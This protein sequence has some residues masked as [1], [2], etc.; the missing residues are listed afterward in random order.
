MEK[1]LI[2]KILND[3][4]FWEKD[5]ASGIK[6]EFYLKKMKDLL[7]GEQVIAITGP[8]RSGKSFLMRQLAKE[9]VK[10]GAEKSDI[11]MVNL[12]DP[13]F[14]LLDKE[15]L[16]RIYEVYLEFFRP[17]RTPYIFLDEVQEV[18]GWEKWVLM[19]QE[20]KKARV[21]IS[22]SNA[23][24]LSRELSTLL[25]GRH[26]DMIVYPLSFREFLEFNNIFIDKESDII[27]KD[28]DI[29]GALR[30]YFE[31]GA[32]PEIVLGANKK[33]GLLNYF[34][35]IL[36]KDLIKRY[37]IRKTEKFKDLL[38]FYFSNISSLITFSSLEK[39]MGFSADTI[40]KFSDYA[41]TAY[42][43]FFLKRF[44]FRVKEQEKSPRK[45]YAIDS[46]LANAVGFR[47]SENLGKLAE[48]I[49]FLELKR[50]NLE[51]PDL[52]IYY[53]KDEKHRE[54]DFVLYRARSVAQLIQ[55]CWDF[56]DW[57]VKDREIKNLIKASHGLKC[58]DLLI[59]NQDIEKE[60]IINDKKI[61]FIPLQKWLLGFN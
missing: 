46:G 28:T 21:V 10:D 35:D 17:K 9:L 50:R 1:N 13:R 56:S 38:K 43:L 37:K 29:A 14:P 45:V 30:N 51:S 33:E 24:L 11:L 36:E 7:S 25:T 42:I 59:I 4:N 12:E 47:F 16:Q 55:V 40:E 58:D 2:L 54:I 53:W 44:S 41:E 34:G 39:A 52:E 19:M 49:V 5:I 18:K 27:L 57:R 15:S 61:K 31:T 26:L 6:R 32:F 3:W 22:G 8:R 23:K 20:L 48:N 60:E